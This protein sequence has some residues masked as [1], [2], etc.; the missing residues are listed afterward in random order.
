MRTSAHILLFGVA[1]MA[2]LGA[3]GAHAGFATVTCAANASQWFD[4][5][6]SYT[7]IYF[8]EFPH[9]TEITDQ[10]APLGAHFQSPLPVWIYDS[11]PPGSQDGMFLYGQTTVSLTFDTPMRAFAMFYPG[12]TYVDF[13]A[14]D[15]LLHRWE[16]FVSGS[17]KFAGFLSDTGFDRV[18]F[19][20]YD[21]AP[22]A[23]PGP[24]SIDS[25]YLATVPG[26]A[27]MRALALAGCLSLRRRGR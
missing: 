19:R 22:W 18:V 8:N 9:G 23:P 13:Y 6:G 14:G 21:S 24:V 4:A 17:P 12:I 27:G 2:T 11:H 7:S 10:Y 5:V 16:Q 3:P 1:C 26:P 20:A 15:L 25:L